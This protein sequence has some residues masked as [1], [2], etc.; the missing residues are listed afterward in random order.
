MSDW[1]IYYT[2]GSVIE[3]DT[4][5]GFVP[6]QQVQAILWTDGRSYKVLTGYDYYVWKGNRWWGTDSNGMS[7]YLFGDRPK[8]WKKVLAGE[9]LPDDQYEVIMRHVHEDRNA[10][11][12]ID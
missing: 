2:D 10:L 11:N 12:V 8:G 3:D 1:Y 5:P 9:W 4:D 6:S 7:I